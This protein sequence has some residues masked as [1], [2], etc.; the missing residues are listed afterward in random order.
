MSMVQYD[1]GFAAIFAIIV[2]VKHK[3][4][5]KRLLNG[6][7]NKFGKKKDKNMNG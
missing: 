7:E 6:T 4:N 3:D 1:T 5:I 2:L